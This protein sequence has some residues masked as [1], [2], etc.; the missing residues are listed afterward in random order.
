MKIQ[1]GTELKQSYTMERSGN[2]EI[3]KGNRAL[4]EKGENAEKQAIIPIDE[5]KVRDV[6]KSLNNFMDAIMKNLHFE[7]HKDS[8]QMMVQVVDAETTKV[9]KTIPPEELLDLAAR[10][11]KMVGLFLDRKV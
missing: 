2:L 5:E 8:G 6:T 10:I 11:D 1:G 9:I 3:G 7:V 4:Q